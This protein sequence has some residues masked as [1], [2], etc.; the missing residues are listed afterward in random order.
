MKNRRTIIIGIAAVTGL[1]I[2]LLVIWLQSD[3]RYSWQE[4]YRNEGKQPYNLSLFKDLLETSYGD[5]FILQEGL[6]RDTTYL[7]AQNTSMIFVNNFMF[8]DSMEIEL[9]KDYV[10][11]GN[12][13][14]ISTGH[15]S[16]LQYAFYEDCVA[17]N[18]TMI[19]SVLA[20]KI[21]VELSDS[22]DNRFDMSFD[23]YNQPEI[24]GWG[25]FKPF[26]QCSELD[27]K[28]EGFFTH[29]EVSYPNYLSMNFGDGKIHFHCAPLIFTNYHLRREEVFDYCNAIFNRLEAEAVYYLV[30]SDEQAPNQPILSES[31]LRFIL[32]QPPLKWAWYSILILALIYVVNAMRREQRAIPVMNLPENQ[33]AGYLDVVYRL[34]RKEGN[35]KHI[36]AIQ[37]R[38]LKNYLRNK[39]Q[40]H[41]NANDEFFRHAAEIL[42]MDYSYLK[43]FFKDLE[44]ASHNSTLSDEELLALDEK[45]NEFYI[46]CP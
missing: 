12:Q 8:L 35:H 26:P 19:R 13:L 22:E 33:T 24:Y 15:I 46:K 40:L 45:I 5:D 17:E 28:T 44:R 16:G 29:E 25:Y 10:S 20:E 1:L 37:L 4:L 21:Q 14:F 39:Y 2:L 38:L 18:D 32:S 34:F 11:R 6:Y 27:L 36:I 9:L 41:F 3:P 7:K 23:R 31:P 43:Q 30:P 42:S